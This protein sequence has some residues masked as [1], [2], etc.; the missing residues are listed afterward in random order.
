[1]LRLREPEKVLIINFR[2]K[3]DNGKVYSIL[4]EKGVLIVPDILANAGG[5]IV[6]YFE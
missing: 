1:M 2:V 3:M 4:N 5:V 6:L